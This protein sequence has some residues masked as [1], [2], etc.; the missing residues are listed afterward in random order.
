[1]WQP[2]LLRLTQENVNN[3][4]TT[5]VAPSDSSPHGLHFKE[6]EL[7]LSVSMFILF[8]FFIAV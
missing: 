5:S 7:R 8:Y 2:V 3:N 1:M 6:F 4:E